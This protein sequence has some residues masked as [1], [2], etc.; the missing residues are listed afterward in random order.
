M[1]GAKINTKSKGK[2]DKSKGNKNLSSNNEENEE[3][4]C[5]LLRKPVLT[6]ITGFAQA[7]KVFDLATEE[8]SEMIK[9]RQM[10]EA[11]KLTE[12][13]PT[14]SNDRIPLTKDITGIVEKLAKIKGRYNFDEQQVTLQ[15]IPNSS[16]AVFQSHSAEKRS[17]NMQAQVQELDSILSQDRAVLQKDGS[18]NVQSSL[19]AIKNGDSDNDNVIQISDDDDSDDGRV[20]KCKICDMQFSTQKT[21]KFHMKKSAAQI[22][23]L[24]EAIQA[25][26]FKMNN[27]PAF[28]EK[29]KNM[30][31][32]APQ[33]ITEEE[34]LDQE[35]QAW[36]DNMESDGELPRCGGCGRTFER[37]AALAA[38]THTC[39]PRSRALARRPPATESKKIEIQIRKD[40]KK[41]PPSLNLMPKADIE[42]K[43]VTDEAQTASKAKAEKIAETAENTEQSIQTDPPEKEVQPVKK[44]N[45]SAEKDEEVMETSQEA[46]EKDSE[47]TENVLEE[48][49]MDIIDDKSSDSAES[50]QKHLLVKQRADKHPISRLP[51]A[52]QIEKNNFAA[53][54]KRIQQDVDLEKLLCKK[55]DS[56]YTSIQDL[57]DHMAEHYKWMR[58]AC[59]LCNFK[60]YD[61]VKVPEHVKIVHKLKGDSDFYFSTVKA[62]DG[63]EALELAEPV[64]LCD[65][66]DESS[67]SRRPSRCSSDSS[68]LSDDSSSSSVRVET[69]ARKR[70]MYHNRNSNKRKKETIVNDETDDVKEGDASVDK[71]INNAGDIESSPTTK[72]FE[73]NSSDVEEL[74]D[75]LSKRHIAKQIPSV[76]SRRPVR[77]KT[78]PKN[79]DFEYD[80]SNL[81]KMEA[82]G[83]RDSQTVTTAPKITQ[84]KKRIQQEFQNNYDNINKEYIGALLLMSNKA[85]DKA[86]AELKTTNFSAPIFSIQKEQR[87]PNVF[88]KPMLPKPSRAEKMSPKKDN[89]EEAKDSSSSSKIS[90][91]QDASPINDTQIDRLATDENGTKFDKDNLSLTKGDIKEKECVVKEQ[92][93]NTGP[94]ESVKPKVKIPSIVPIKFRRQSLELMKNPI[95]NKNITDFSKAGMKT[96]IL[97][98]KPIN[99]NKDG[100]SSNTPLKFQTIKLKETNKGLTTNEDK[101]ND[102]IVVVKVP[103]VNRA[104]ARTVP[105]NNANI[106][107]LVPLTKTENINEA[108]E[109]KIDTKSYPIVV[110]ENNTEKSDEDSVDIR[111]N[112]S[113]QNSVDS[114]NVSNVSQSG[115]PDLVDKTGCGN[116][117]S[118]IASEASN[119]VPE[120]MDIEELGTI[121]SEI[122]ETVE[123]LEMMT[124]HYVIH[125][126]IAYAQ[127]R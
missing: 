67:E 3:Y 95:I 121:G 79:E 70:K 72:M 94:S 33:K 74:E 114:N 117:I 40:Y 107:R 16:I 54:K 19:N 108:V 100:V 84:T 98:I 81:L 26:A 78:K 92:S 51:F 57:H 115:T 93:T 73:E 9:I 83:Y 39:Q 89:L 24:R 27:P 17:D 6:S 102:Q 101:P 36:M 61:F 18:F 13:I 30:K 48:A 125:L 75:K 34:R 42:S 20:P 97:L 46:A 106:N 55:C 86:A 4:D 43:P 85:V 44:T 112:E 87:P 110:D 23:R 118:S 68:R 90:K 71:T 123:K 99:R 12:A 104:V 119:E 59:K 50:P 22:R 91:I 126:T 63:A 116:E 31:A 41:G 35:N 8:A 88:A 105:D 29:K 60:H 45:E 52:L 80:L 28:Y 96:K 122:L 25:K 49:T 82:Q 11:L 2:D 32:A 113:E 124:S 1:A 65:G 15:K 56:N 47:T 5:S 109:N 37:R 127:C 10:E 120:P 62:I 76:V 69:G 111:G 64:E 58:Y 66:N 38:H 103:K 53:F 77:K 21:F 7:R 14:E